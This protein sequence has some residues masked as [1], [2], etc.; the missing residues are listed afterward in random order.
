MTP[1]EAS[2]PVVPLRQRL[3]ASGEVPALANAQVCCAMD[4]LAQLA[5]DTGYLLWLGQ[6][7]LKIYTAPEGYT[8]ELM[9]RHAKRLLQSDQWK[10]EGY[11]VAYQMLIEPFCLIAERDGHP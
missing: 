10:E 8:F 5:G 6:R 4:G 1:T 2:V 7:L 3:L 9:V 11:E